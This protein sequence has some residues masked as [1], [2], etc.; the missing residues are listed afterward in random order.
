ME[1]SRAQ[2]LMK[3]TCWKLYQDYKV[4]ID[5]ETLAGYRKVKIS[6]EAW[7]AVVKCK[8]WADE[9]LD[10]IDIRDGRTTPDQYN[11]WVTSHALRNGTLYMADTTGVKDMSHPLVYIDKFSEDKFVTLRGGDRELICTFTHNG[12][13]YEIR[14]GERKY[15]PLKPNEIVIV[16]GD[17][18][19]KGVS[20][21]GCTTEKQIIDKFSGYNSDFRDVF[22]YSPVAVSQINRDISNIQRI[23][24]SDG[25]L[26]PQ[27]E[28][29]KG[30]GGMP[31]DADL[32]L[33]VFNP[34]RYKSF[35]DNG[36][37]KGYNIRDY[38]VNSS[39]Y[40]RYRLLSILK[41]SY[42][43][44]DVDFG[45]KF[46]GEINGFFTLPKPNDDG[47]P[48]KELLQVYTDIAAGY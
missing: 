20:Q 38:M 34:F 14:Q 23:K 13:N 2:K 37:Y 44:D 24:H 4:L 25:D 42:G 32:L 30:S 1:R 26:S 28:D 36:M 19:G 9:M 5:A 11:D 47:T 45:M 46:L 12:V 10:Y 27:L 22:K 18:L 33:A 41:N 21:I 29:T 48:T 35:D 16:V 8:D 31:E 3:W 17:H 7:K 39:G 6:D 43:V 40:N 15:F